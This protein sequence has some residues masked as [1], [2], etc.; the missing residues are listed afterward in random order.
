MQLEANMNKITNIK[1]QLDLTSSVIQT[2]EP[3]SYFAMITIQCEE[4][5]CKKYLN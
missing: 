4:S 5:N 1:I 3:G 2:Q